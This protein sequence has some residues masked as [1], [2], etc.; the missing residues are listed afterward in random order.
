MGVGCPP[1]RGQS[2]AS[3][4][5]EQRLAAVLVADV[6]GYTRLMAEDEDETVQIRARGRSKRRC[7][8]NSNP[9]GGPGASW[10]LLADIATHEGEPCAVNPG[11]AAPLGRDRPSAPTS[12]AK[13]RLSGAPLTMPS[14][15]P[16]RAAHQMG[17]YGREV[18]GNGRSV[19]SRRPRIPGRGGPV[20]DLAP[21]HR[22]GLRS[23][24]Q[25]RPVTSGPIAVIMTSGPRSTPSADTD[26]AYL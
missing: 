8:R 14:T 26:G 9:A 23:L 5:T 12:S 18:L 24:S 21:V 3:E 22:R 25:G 1:R 6:V 17:R 16:R 4:G 10:A 19:W 20:E 15:S 13:F 7:A 2:V 11:G